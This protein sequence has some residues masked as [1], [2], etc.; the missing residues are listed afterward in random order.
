MQ[1]YLPPRCQYYFGALLVEF[2]VKGYH[3]LRALAA[4]NEDVK[5]QRQQE[6]SQEYVTLKLQDVMY[7]LIPMLEKELEEA[8]LLKKVLSENPEEALG[9]EE[10][11]EQRAALEQ[12]SY[13]QD[14]F[15]VDDNPIIQGDD[16]EFK[17]FNASAK[18]SRLNKD[19]NHAKLAKWE[20]NE[21][22]GLKVKL[23][24]P[25]AGLVKTLIMALG[26]DQSVTQE[27][28]ILKRNSMQMLKLSDFSK[29]AQYEGN[30]L[31]R[32]TADG[33]EMLPLRPSPS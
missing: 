7:K 3:N 32:E 28:I 30:Y 25:L 19:E 2:L 12:D 29:E 15:V 6:F 20:F 13:E 22:L 26:L 10:A 4:E 24:N 1:E 27:L 9:A 18:K 21:V 8:R 14:S 16:E 33:D 23:D 31:Q 5:A 11:E 17:K